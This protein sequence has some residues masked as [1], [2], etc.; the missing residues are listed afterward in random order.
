MVPVLRAIPLVLNH[1]RRGRI[2]LRL[3]S[4][5]LNFLLLLLLLNLRHPNVLL[6]DPFVISF[7]EVFCVIYNLISYLS[8]II[9]NNN[10]L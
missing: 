3:E 10:L 1:F 6:V 8:F 7:A 2:S 5:L 9:I 4:A